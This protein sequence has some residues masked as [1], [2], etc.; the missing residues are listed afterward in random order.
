[1]S[2]T[3]PTESL[4]DL[5]ARKQLPRHQFMDSATLRWIEENRPSFSSGTSPRLRPTSQRLLHRAAI[6]TDWLAERQIADSLHGIRHAL[7][8]AALAALL[9]EITRLDEDDTA[10]LIMAAAVHDC[11]R[12]HDKDD[13]GHGA[14]AAIWLTDNANAVWGH[15]DRPASP[16]SVDQ[17]ATAVRL[18]DVPYGAFTPEDQ[19]DHHRVEALTD[20]LKAADA[21]DRYRLPKLKWWPN[22]AHLRVPQ[23]EHLRAVAFDLVVWSEAA[24][25]DDQDSASAVLTALERKEIA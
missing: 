11:R 12:L 19:A 21:L 5:A 4:V 20:L 23:I 7:R 14:R 10:T 18:H 1:M 6:P 3:P 15:F 16:R 17:A 13:H 2:T 25:L 8:T 24:H 22:A 9:A